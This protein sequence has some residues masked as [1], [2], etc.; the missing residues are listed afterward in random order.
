M[1]L[2]SAKIASM[3]DISAVRTDSSDSRVD[4]AVRCAQKYSFY[5]VTILPAQTLLAKKI[6]ENLGVAAKLGGNVGFP[7]GEQ[8]TTIKALETQELIKMGV[9][10]IDMVINVAALISGRVNDVYRDIQAVVEAA[11]GHPVK[12][13]LECHYLNNDQIRTG[14][15][16][17]IRAG[18]A[19]VK[20][21]T[22][23]APSGA[24]LENIALIKQHV[25]DS[26]KIKASGGIRDLETI[27]AM[28]DIGVTRFGISAKNVAKIF[29]QNR[30]KLSDD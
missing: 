7:S 6:I 12:T 30:D 28:Y 24:T 8:T 14:C 21:A 18:A 29:D 27:N 17:A 16:Q 4:E 15:D 5:L 11:E 13:I 9:D 25:G 3:I 19:F 23:W 26:I 20:T 10:E 22:G 2:S 1:K